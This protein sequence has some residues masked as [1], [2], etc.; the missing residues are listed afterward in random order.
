MYNAMLVHPGEENIYAHAVSIY[1]PAYSVVPAASEYEVANDLGGFPFMFPQTGN[2]T[3]PSNISGP[4]N[5]LSPPNIRGPPHRPTFDPPN[6]FTPKII[7]DSENIARSTVQTFLD[8]K[9]LDP[10]TLLQ[11]TN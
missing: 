7:P 4:S 9:P 5:A 2:V 8:P 10:K 3:V 11:R 1:E 6:N